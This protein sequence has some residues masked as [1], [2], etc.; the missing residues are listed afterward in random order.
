MVGKSGKPKVPKTYT[1]EAMERVNYA[2]YAPNRLDCKHSSTGWG[3]ICN[4][5][6]QYKCFFAAFLRERE[7]ERE[8]IERERERERDVF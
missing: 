6:Y 1:E 4:K 3:M 8:S 5:Y 7:R 2:K